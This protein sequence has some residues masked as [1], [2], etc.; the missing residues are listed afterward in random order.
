MD[1]LIGTDL[2]YES[3]FFSKLLNSLLELSEEGTRWILGQRHRRE[4]SEVI[5]SLAA[6]AGI[7]DDG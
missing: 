4:F 2:A 6:C 3:V 7:A 1:L 5:L